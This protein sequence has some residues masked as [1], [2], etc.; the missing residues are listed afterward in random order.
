MVQYTVPVRHNRI[1]SE[2]EHLFVV[3]CRR[4]REL[5]NPHVER[6]PEMGEATSDRRP[7]DYT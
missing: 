5:D 1:T 3:L 7:D 4:N 2:V 6:G